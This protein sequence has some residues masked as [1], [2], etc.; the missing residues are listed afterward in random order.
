MEPAAS[1]SPSPLSPDGKLLASGGADGRIVLW[2]V[3]M[4]TQKGAAMEPYRSPVFS[5]AV[6]H[7]GKTIASGHQSGSV[8]LWNTETV[9]LIQTLT[10]HQRAVYGIA[11]SSDDMRLATTS[12]DRRVQLH[13][14]PGQAEAGAEPGAAAKFS[15]VRQLSGVGGRR[16]YGVDFVKNGQLATGTDKGDVVL[17]NAGEKP[18]PRFARLIADRE[19]ETG[20]AF[21]GDGTMLVLYSQDSL[22]V[23]PVETLVADPKS[24][25]IERLVKADQKKVNFVFAVGRGTYSKDLLTVGEDSSIKRWEW[26]ATKQRH[27]AKTLAPPGDD[28][29]TAAAYAAESQTLVF[30]TYNARHETTIWRADLAKGN[31]EPILGPSRDRRAFLLA[32]APKA[33][34]LAMSYSQG[35][36]DSEEHTELWSL[37]RGERVKIFARVLYS[38]VFS[39]DGK[40]LA[41]GDSDGKVGLWDTQVLGGPEVFHVEPP[42][43][44]AHIRAVT[45]LAF[46]PDGRK[47]ASGSGDGTVILWDAATGQQLSAPLDVYFDDRVEVLFDPDGRFLATSAFREGTNGP[48]ATFIVLWEVSVPMLLHR[49]CQTA[50][51][52]MTAAEWGSYF[53][54]E[55]HRITC[56]GTAADEADVLA[57]AGDKDGAQRRFA[58]AWNAMLAMGELGPHSEVA[59][60]I[61]WLGSIAG[62][63]ATVQAACDKA[64]EWADPAIRDVYRDS[65]GLARALTGDKQGAIDDFESVV[66]YFNKEPGR[67]GASET[68]LRR[69]EEWIDAL[70]K[71]NDP[72]NAKLLEELRIED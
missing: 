32:V 15:E 34:L 3:K 14:L 59:N 16:F 17:W 65:R 54:G 27:I 69:R 44:D 50:G 21:T 9:E 56:P 6:S 63:A 39:P 60:H 49:A 55:P 5:I 13:T 41:F 4:R 35:L 36:K 72:F 11:F 10:S 45:S 61:C 31:P 70:R 48:G 29:I 18:W 12:T 25:E 26:D 43:L 53:A 68:F 64:V 8:Y 47:L 46:S 19:E 1:T 30:A 62:F 37:E 71:G 38:L 58:A 42:S 7:N 51:R 2:D 40:R 20:V 57:L 33:N 67:A 24:P 52:N 28:E 23:R 22:T 66:A